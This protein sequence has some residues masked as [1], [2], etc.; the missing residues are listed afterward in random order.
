MSHARGDKAGYLQ[1]AFLICAGVLALVG[2]GMSLAGR[3]LGL[4]LEKKPLP[5]KRSLDL[6]DEAA[7]A[8]YR[9]VAKQT[10]DNAEVLD[11]LGTNDY[12]QWVLEDPAR[13]IDSAV[14]RV[15]LF[16]TYYE[17]PDR[18]PHVP[19]ECYAGG[20]YQR[21]GTE[22]VRL[23]VGQGQRMREI[24]G[25]YLAFEASG[26]TVSLDARR[27]GVLYLFRVNG[28]YAGNRDRARMALNRN[29]LSQHAYFCKV[30]LVFNQTHGTATKAEAVAAGER[31][32]A[33]VLPLLER[34]HWPDGAPAQ[35][36]DTSRQK[37]DSTQ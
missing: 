27:F 26:T 23:Q 19:E 29:I 11:S 21:Q 28:E 9:V 4:Y 12:I 5:L 22:D 15:M 31:L 2:G 3:R 6:L 14:R 17:Q 36:K 13:G 34:D 25:R 33:V 18:V 24:P 37:K 20:G 8:P 30:E 35:I 1:P 7:L 10:I 32:L 16:V